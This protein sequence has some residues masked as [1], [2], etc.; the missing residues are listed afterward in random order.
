MASLPA[1]GMVSVC[2][3]R[4]VAALRSLLLS[5]RFRTDWVLD[6]YSDPVYH[7]QI[8]ESSMLTAVKNLPW[9][10]HHI[11]K[12][13]CRA[14]SS[15][16]TLQY[17][18]VQNKMRCQECAV[19][20]TRS[21]SKSLLQE[22]GDYSPFHVSSE[23]QLL[24]EPNLLKK[25]TLKWAYPSPWRILSEMQLLRNSHATLITTPV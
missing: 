10:F 12:W 22:T 15:G 7:F 3:W 5:T 24:T 8:K 23:S 9:F 2:T 6:A 21:R 13:G 16:N 19:S 11:W 1:P 17:I 14:F 18:G 4:M 25:L 20:K